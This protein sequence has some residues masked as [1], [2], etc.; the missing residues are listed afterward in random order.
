MERITCCSV[1]AT[2]LWKQKWAQVSH[3]F[4]FSIQKH[5][6]SRRNWTEISVDSFP[7]IFLNRTHY[8]I[9]YKFRV[10][11]QES[12]LNGVLHSPVSREKLKY[13]PFKPY[14]RSDAMTM[15]MINRAERDAKL[16]KPFCGNIIIRMKVSPDKKRT[17]R[18]TRSFF[19][20]SL[21]LV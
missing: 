3:G 20:S 21:H 13:F 1:F 14:F 15:I 7:L 10:E 16:V 2:F 19:Q 6:E 8:T 17:Q 9:E 18:E 4:Y 11:I 5:T 12:W